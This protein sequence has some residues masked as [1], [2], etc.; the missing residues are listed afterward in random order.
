V[1]NR[2]RHIEVP[3]KVNAWVDSVVAPL[4]EALNE[5]PNI[6]TTS[7]CEG[8][9]GFA[10]VT[11]AYRG[12]VEE[13]SALVKN[14]SIRLRLKVQTERAYR[15]LLEWVA[16]GERPLGTLLVHRDDIQTLAAVIRRTANG[17]QTNQSRYGSRG[18]KPRNS[19]SHPTRRRSAR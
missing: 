6:W 19:T 16:G 8:H 9:N 17:D 1:N 14:L 2:T 10:H 4:V 11:F 7:S 5:F 18:I 3:V 12:E 13:F 15:I